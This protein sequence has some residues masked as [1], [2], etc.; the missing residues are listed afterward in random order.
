MIIGNGLLA[1]GFSKRFGHRD[2]VVIFASGVSNSQEQRPAEFARERDL[3]CN[4]LGGSNARLVYFGSCGVAG[5]EDT[6]YMRHKREMESRVLERDG[7]QV[8]R[9]PQVVGATGNPNTLTNFLHARV[10]NQEPFTVWAQ[11]E[12]NLIDIDDI[13]AIGSALIEQPPTDAPVISIASARSLTMPE[14]VKIFER[15]LGKRAQA[16]FIDRGDRLP[17]DSA[18]AVHTA[19][20]LGIDLGEGYVES[21]IRKY[22]EPAA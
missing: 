15:V 14:L 9:L 16:S 11:A 6:P 21:L 22:Y 2:D 12:R 18:I 13:V 19:S 5:S 3:L 7:S 8:L 17:I 10:S 4:S 20:R 1:Q